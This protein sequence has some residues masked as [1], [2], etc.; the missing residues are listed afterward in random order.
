M[1]FTDYFAE[2]AAHSELMNFVREQV[3]AVY[4]QAMEK[5]SY[6]MPAW[7]RENG[8]VFIYAAPTAKHLGIYPQAA[9]IAENKRAL[10][11]RGLKFSKGAIQVPYDYP[12]EELAALLREIVHFNVK[13]SPAR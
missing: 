10:E 5:I 2:T 12:D 11:A 1:N 9:Y 3:L 4:P 13:G 6:G 7:A 8:K